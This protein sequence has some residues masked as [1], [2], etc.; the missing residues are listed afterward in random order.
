MFL[1]NCSHFW[2]TLY[3]SLNG[4]FCYK[5]RCNSIKGTF[6]VM[7]C[8]SKDLECF[9]IALEFEGFRVLT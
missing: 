5:R 7:P 6:T 4:Q 3:A 2:D 1:K 9:K 8:A